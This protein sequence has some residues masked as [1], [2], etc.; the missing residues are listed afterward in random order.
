MDKQKYSKLSESLSDVRKE[1]KD[2]IINTIKKHGRVS[3]NLSSEEQDDHNNYPVTSTL[4]GRHNNP[5]IR[6]TDVYLD[7]TE[8]I[9]ADGI[10]S[11]TDEKRRQFYIYSEQY[12]DIFIFLGHVLS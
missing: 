9:Y 7:E 5:Q 6:I 3:L 8:N 11:D 10:D 1:I 2:F 4:Y 12:A